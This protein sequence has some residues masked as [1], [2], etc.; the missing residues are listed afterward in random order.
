MFPWLKESWFRL[1]EVL[2][3]NRPPHAV[4]LY[5]GDGLGKKEIALE[6]G[7]LFLCENPSL[8]GYC[9]S[10]HSCNLSLSGNHPDYHHVSAPARTKIGIDAVRDIISFV[11]LTPKLDI[12]KAVIIENAEMLTLEAANAVLKVLEEPQGRTMFILTADNPDLLLPT[13]RSRCVSFKIPC[14][15]FNEAKDWI[16]SQLSGRHC[17]VTEEIYR[18]NRQSP[19]ETVRFIMNG[20]DELF[21][22]LTLAFAQIMQEPAR[23][24]QLIDLMTEISV[25]IQTDEAA[26]S[27]H[28][29]DEKTSKKTACRLSLSD[30][31]GWIYYMLE[32][33]LRYRVTGSYGGNLILKNTRMLSFFDHISVECLDR[34]VSRLL[35]MVRRERA[36]VNSWAALELAAF[37][38]EL[39][40][41]F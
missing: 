8:S 5:G 15:E 3:G 22:R 14:P 40:K 26:R 27:E 21:N 20:Y 28:S 37:F 11:A 16:Y 18:I 31:Y 29:A 10:C 24:S 1:R 4:L 19:V 2:I 34:S 25:K 35:D 6:L 9:G 13:V 23:V 32:D 41:G 30:V 38:N 7:R 36:M 12:G 33:I 17:T 39:I